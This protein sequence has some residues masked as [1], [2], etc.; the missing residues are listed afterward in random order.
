MLRYVPRPRCAL[1]WRELHV[2]QV[3]PQADEDNAGAAAT[4]AAAAAAAA[5][6]PL[7]AE[8]LHV[9]TGRQTI[10]FLEW[11]ELLCRCVTRRAQLCNR[12]LFRRH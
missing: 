3:T 8:A 6:P 2:L 9:H 5:L 10:S 12:A 1:L 4:P 11:T 7:A